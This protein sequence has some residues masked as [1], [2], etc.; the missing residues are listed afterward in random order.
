MTFLL[1]DGRPKKLVAAYYEHVGTYQ[2]P[3]YW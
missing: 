2:I 3:P 1:A